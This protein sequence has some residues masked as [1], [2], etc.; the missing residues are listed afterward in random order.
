[1]NVHSRPTERRLKRRCARLGAAVMAVL[2]VASCANGGGGESDS[3]SSS[4]EKLTVALAGSP[5]T[6]D[7]HRTSAFITQ[8]VAWH[9]YEGLWTIDSEY[10]AQPML[11]KSGELDPETNI[12]TINLRENVVFHDGSKLDS[13]D[14]VASLKRWRD[15]A[16]YGGLFS[17]I[18]KEIK[19]PSEF[20]V[21]LKVTQPSPVIEQ[22]LAFP[23]QQAA[24]MPSE[25]IEQAGDSG[26]EKPIGTGP[27]KFDERVLGQYTKLARFEDYVPREEA[28]DG[29]AGKREAKVETLEFRP[30]SEVSVRRD[31]VIT[32]QVDV[33][34][35]LA[36]DMLAGLESAADAAPMLVKPY[37]WSMAVFDKTE[38]PFNDVKAR[39]AFMSAL[40][41]KPIMQAAFGS[42]DFYRLQPGILQ[43]EQ[44]QW[45]SDAGSDIYNQQD[46]DEARQLLEESGYDGEE[47]TWVTTR[48]YPYMYTNATVAQQQLEKVGF[49]IKLEVVDYAT[50]VTRRSQPEQYAIFSGAT[51]FTADP[52]IWPIWDETW[53]GFWE[54][55][56]KDELVQSLNTAMDVEE[57][58]AVWDELQGYFYE[59]VPMVKFG[60]LFDLSAKGTNVEGL[61]GSPFPAFWGVSVGSDT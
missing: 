41:M 10:K 45:A 25:L 37:W 6:L 30:M 55:D 11:A 58:Q 2:F 61:E 5:S 20:V 54:D 16:S 19:A 23:N 48:E 32:G 56:Q 47:L 26:I 17:E 18:V 13:K 24:I 4:Q 7:P 1:M 60:D 36:P 46:V 40:D 8:Q 59:Q 39:R 49:N 3:G 14:V 50:I 29:L 33:A 15:A 34:Q 31:A 43:P 51:T 57:R 42:E 44:K 22:L 12:F 38:A 9:F 21:E 28:P 35:S 53:P 52:G 27:Y